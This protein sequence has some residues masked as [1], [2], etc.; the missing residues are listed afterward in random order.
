MCMYTYFSYK[1]EEEK[2]GFRKFRAI[3]KRQLM[4]NEEEEEEEK[5]RRLFIYLFI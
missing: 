4:K 1:D 2:L 3:E 5:Y